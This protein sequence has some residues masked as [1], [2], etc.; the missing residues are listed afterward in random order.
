MKIAA[1]IMLALCGLAG[2]ASAR[3]Q[4]NQ[5][6]SKGDNAAC[7]SYDSS[8]EVSPD[9]TCTALTQKLLQGL[10]NA[11]K[12]QVQ[13]A[14]KEPGNVNVDGSLHYQSNY[15]RGDGGGDGDINFIF[16]SSGNVSIISGM[17]R[18]LGDE[19]TFYEYVW[20]ANGFFCTDLPGSG[21]PC[22]GS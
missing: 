22:N 5:I 6:P 2:L 11:T 19:G 17:I 12:E 13:S 7:W 4:P 20:N 14:M 15:L 16:N 8:Q 3:A 1:I 21:K 10:E 18:P 9:I